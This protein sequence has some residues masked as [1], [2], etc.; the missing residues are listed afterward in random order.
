MRKRLLEHLEGSKRNS[1]YGLFSIALLKPF[2]I[3]APL[4]PLLVVA[5]LKDKWHQMAF[6]SND[7]SLTE[8]NAEML[9]EIL[10]QS[11][12]FYE[13]EIYS[14]N[15]ETM[16][17]LKYLNEIYLDGEN[18]LPP[19]ILFK[20]LNQ[21]LLKLPRFT[22][23]TNKQ[24][25]EVLKVKQI[26]RSSEMDPLV[27]SKEFMNFALSIE[28]YHEIKEYLE[29]FVESFKKD[30]LKETFAVFEV[31]N[32]EQIR[33]K[34]ADTIQKSPQLKELVQI[35]EQEQNFDSFIVN[36][37]GVQ[38]E[39]WSDVTYDSYFATLTQLLTIVD[40]ETIRVTEGEQV[41]STIKEMDLSV[42]GNTIYNQLHRIVT[43]GG[44]TM[45]PEEV[46]YILYRILK[47]VK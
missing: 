21:W 38:L 41:I 26:I 29:V 45:N 33:V 20:E 13:Y 32:V 7:F 4:V 16:E 24:P 17:M 39:D 5:L 37:V 30:L 6:Y 28:Q 35:L 25:P 46:K 11:A 9:Y 8:M 3:R 27:A 47:E 23:I 1:I 10:E 31:Q 43:A 36:V 22:Q 2:G 18:T 44:R 15:E 19:N 14:L 12:E 40:S 34:H 42:K